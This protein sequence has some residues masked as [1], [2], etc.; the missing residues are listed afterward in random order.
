M[1][2]MGVVSSLR[3][4]DGKQV[5]ILVMGNKSN[6]GHCHEDKGSFMLEYA[7][8]TF[9]DDPGTFDYSDPRAE[10][11]GECEWHNMLVPYG[12]GLYP[13][14]DNPLLHDIKPEASGDEMKFHAQVNVGVG[15]NN[16]YDH[17][18]RTWDSPKPNV[19]VITDDYKLNQGHGV[20]FHWMTMLDVVINGREIYINGTNAHIV[21]HTPEDCEIS[22]DKS[23]E[24]GG[25]VFNRINIC[26][27]RQKGKFILKV[28]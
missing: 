14:P 27:D 28:E 11:A 22:V 8:E 16:V 5:K 9:A 12:P 18:K 7:G 4:F 15:W 3:V 6:A 23:P 2:E 19:L 1:P 21:L 26:R 24:F 20:N 25:N 17:W 10:M 13:H